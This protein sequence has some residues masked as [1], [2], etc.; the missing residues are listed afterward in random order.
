VVVAVVAVLMM[1]VALH[2]VVGV[3][4]VRN[5]V[6]TAA[7]SVA[8]AGVV[9]VT[10]VLRCAA[11]RVLRADLDPVLIDMAVVGMVEMAVVQVIDVAIVAD[12]GVAASLPV[13]VRMPL[14]DVVAAVMM[15]RHGTASVLA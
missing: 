6:V 5:R 11:G 8:M 12:R 9:A 2:E 10:G 14:M 7:W 4:A 13:L 3:V 15:V 1:Q